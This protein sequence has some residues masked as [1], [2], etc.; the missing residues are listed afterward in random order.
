MSPKINSGLASLISLKP[1]G[2]SGKFSKKG[3]F[4]T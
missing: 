3:G 2:V 1:S 4:F